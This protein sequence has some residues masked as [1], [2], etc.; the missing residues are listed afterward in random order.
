MLSRKMPKNN[1]YSGGE[2]SG[3]NPNQTLQN[4]LSTSIV[5]ERT[6]QQDSKKGSWGYLSP[7]L[8]YVEH[9]WDWD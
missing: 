9:S 3:Q 7:Q 8:T 5:G 4:N 6:K 2:T 1:A